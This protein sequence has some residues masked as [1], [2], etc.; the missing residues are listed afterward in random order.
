MEKHSFV[1]ACN[2]YFGRKEGQNLTEFQAELKALS[3]EDR[4]YFKREFLKVGIE[5]TN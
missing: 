1:A 4:E 3:I 2:K 5:V